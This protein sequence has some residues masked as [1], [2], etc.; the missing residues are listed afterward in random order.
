MAL[1]KDWWKRRAELRKQPG[2]AAKN[3][4]P[5]GP[6]LAFSTHPCAEPKRLSAKVGE[7]RR[8]GRVGQAYSRRPTSPYQAQIPSRGAE[9]SHRKG[10]SARVR[11]THPTTQ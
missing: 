5:Y 6:R 4:A 1:R 8:S 3:P 11:L 9:S 10:G 2:Y 7:K